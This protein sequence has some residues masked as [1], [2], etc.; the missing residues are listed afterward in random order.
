MKS[1]DQLLEEAISRL[2]S[3]PNTKGP[4]LTITI[5]DKCTNEYGDVARA[6]TQTLLKLVKGEVTTPA[7]I[8]PYLN[9]LRK[10]CGT[11][12]LARSV[13]PRRLQLAVDAKLIN[14]TI[15]YRRVGD[16]NP[17]I[18]TISTHS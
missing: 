13:M 3:P 15:R 5:D 18:Y 7:N 8:Q 16:S 17:P 9:D 14:N 10:H 12:L 1:A 2:I 4:W 6:L 11:S